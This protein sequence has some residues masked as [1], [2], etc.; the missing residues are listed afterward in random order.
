[1][2]AMFIKAGDLYFSYSSGTILRMSHGKK[3]KTRLPALSVSLKSPREPCFICHLERNE[4]KE[5][6]GCHERTSFFFFFP[7]IIPLTSDTP[8]W[9]MTG[10]SYQHMLYQPVTDE[11]CNRQFIKEQDVKSAPATRN[12]KQSEPETGVTQRRRHLFIF[13]S[14]PPCNAND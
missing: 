10:Q 5:I 12:T 7:E 9:V 11:R 8:R 4:I 2:L 3:K 6:R 1:M 14:T 13:A